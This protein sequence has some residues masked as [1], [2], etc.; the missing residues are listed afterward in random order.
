MGVHFY[1]VGNISE[2]TSAHT[3]VLVST[4]ENITV[5]VRLMVMGIKYKIS[6]LF[7][8]RMYRNVL[9]LVVVK[10]KVTSPRK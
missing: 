4:K 7:V 5:I 3:N 9:L 8:M 10:L 6:A 1:E 2:Q